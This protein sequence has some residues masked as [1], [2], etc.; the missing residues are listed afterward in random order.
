MDKDTANSI[1]HILA[2]MQMKEPPALH[3]M[4][5]GDHGH[6]MSHEPFKMDP[7]PYPGAKSSHA[8]SL[9]YIFD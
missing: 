9:F 5:P 6:A 3:W 2:C 8:L 1:K 7:R 4:L